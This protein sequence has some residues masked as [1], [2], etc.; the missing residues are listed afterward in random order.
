[1]RRKSKWRAG[2]SCLPGTWPKIGQRWTPALSAPECIRKAQAGSSPSS[3]S[4]PPGWGGLDAQHAWSSCAVPGPQARAL[5]RYSTRFA[6][7][8]NS[9]KRGP[10]SV[11]LVLR[12]VGRAGLRLARAG[13]FAHAPCGAAGDGASRPPWP[14]PQPPKSLKRRCGSGGHCGAGSGWRA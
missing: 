14:T 12:W 9:V 4:P 6:L 13:G 1:M 10:S 11:A 5:A 3:P 7:A 2:G 8:L